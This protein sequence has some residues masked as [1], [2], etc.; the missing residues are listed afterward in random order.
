MKQSILNRYSELT[1]DDVVL[2]DDGNGIYIDIWRS[3]KPKPSMSQIL[4]W[5]EEDNFIDVKQNKLIE[6]D[7]S[8]TN[9]IL[10]KF[11]ATLNEVEYEFSYDNEAQSRFNGIGILFLGNKITQIPWTAYLNGERVRINLTKEDFDTVSMAALNHQN[12][13]V[14]RYNQ[15]FQDANNATNINEVNAIVW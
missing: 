5:V 9:T 4:Q 11:K 2:R 10:G 3:T 6:L 14:I 12:N 8:C 1:S 13:N 7:T 15:L